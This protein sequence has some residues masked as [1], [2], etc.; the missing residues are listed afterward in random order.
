[1]LVI[2]WTRA[3]SITTP[4]GWT[5]DVTVGSG[6][7]HAAFTR[8][9]SSE[10]TSQSFTISAADQTGWVYYEFSGVDTTT[11]VRATASED[12]TGGTTSRGSGTTDTSPQSGDYAVAGF[13]SRDDISAQS[14]TNSFT[15]DS[16]NNP[17]NTSPVAEL[18]VGTKALTSSGAV[19]TTMSWTTSSSTR[20][21][22]VVLAQAATGA[23]VKIYNG[24][25]WVEGIPKVYNGST[26][27]EGTWKT[28]NGT[29]W[30]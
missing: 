5:K 21:L 7:E 18:S 26:W 29:G 2:F 22:I 14:F 30:E 16:T 17:D 23:L 11:P 24:S 15:F 4:S 27:D 9:A 1:M 12:T 6:D 19:S 13:G 3:T 10:G 20:G 28:Y 8:I 25:S